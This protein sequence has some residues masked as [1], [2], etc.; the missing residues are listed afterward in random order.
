MDQPSST[1]SATSSGLAS[2]VLVRHNELAGRLAGHAAEL[3]GA[4]S[5]GDDRAACEH[6]RIIAAWCSEHL[7][8]TL[9]D[10]DAAAHRMI[11]A[12]DPDTGV[13]ITGELTALRHTAGLLGEDN[14]AREAAVET[15]HLRLHLHRL[16]QLLENQAVAEIV[17]GLHQPATAVRP[18]YVELRQAC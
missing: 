11:A 15:I 13:L 9:A 14:G 18:H 7:E 12:G 1:A 5:R 16:Q 4:A 8:P 2:A 6:R 10:L 3:L 17:G